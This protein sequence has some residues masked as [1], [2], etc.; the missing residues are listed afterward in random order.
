MVQQ[1]AIYD[2]GCR[3]MVG[4]PLSLPNKWND[5]FDRMQVGMFSTPDNRCLT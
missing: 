1:M 5:F 4:T 3:I 2:Q